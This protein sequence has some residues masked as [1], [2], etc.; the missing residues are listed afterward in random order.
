MAGAVWRV[1]CAGLCHSQH[2]GAGRAVYRC[3]GNGAAAHGG[4]GAVGIAGATFI[5]LLRIAMATTAQGRVVDGYGRP[6]GVGAGGRYT[7]GAGG[8]LPCTPRSR[9]I[10]VRLRAA[11]A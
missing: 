8:L 5:F 6:S 10:Q 2:G 9:Q 4:A 11:A 1:G 7:C 3:M